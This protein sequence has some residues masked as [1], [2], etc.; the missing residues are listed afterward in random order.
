MVSDFPITSPVVSFAGPIIG[1]GLTL[2]RDDPLS[3]LS[4]I[5]QKCCGFVQLSTF[6]TPGNPNKPPFRGFHLFQV[7]VVFPIH[8]NPWKLLCSKMIDRRDTQFQSGTTFTCTGKV[9]GFLGHHTMVHP[10]QLEQDYVFIVAPDTWTFLERSNRRF[11]SASPM[12]STANQQTSPLAPGRSKFMTPSKRK[13][14]NISG[15]GTS[16]PSPAVQASASSRKTFLMPSKHILTS[17]P[18]KYAE[19]YTARGRI[20]RSIAAT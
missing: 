4:E 20:L 18:S 6:I 12:S 8:V 1:S 3:G 16:S 9:V 2:L 14:E 19:W 10:P 15:L 17:Y 5:Q 7:F 13:S 11:V